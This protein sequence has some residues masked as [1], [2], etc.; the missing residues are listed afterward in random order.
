MRHDRS[1]APPAEGDAGGAP[2]AE[3][4]KRVAVRLDGVVYSY[5]SIKAV[6]GVTLEIWSGKVMCLVGPNGSGKTTLLKLVASLVRP[7]RGVVYVNGKDARLYRPGEIARA[8]SFSEPHL[9]RT[10]PMRAIDFVLTSRY[11]FQRT[12]Q[13]FESEEDLRVVESVAE[14]LGIAHLL[15]RRLDQLSSG[16]LQRVVIAAALAKR[17][18]VLLLDEPSAFLDVRNRFEVMEIVRRYARERNAAVVVA[19]HDLF[20][21]SLYCDS[22]ALMSGGRIAALGPPADV[23]SSEVA[24]RVYGV[25]IETVRVDG[26]TVIAVPLPPQPGGGEDGS[27]NGRERPDESPRVFNDAS[28]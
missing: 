15:E 21:A 1:T 6:D 18:R 23:F 25:G 4:E 26:T 17:P 10:L 7:L 8:F 16:E 12:L 9:P 13:Y 19:L 20:T 27:R 5:G 28:A 3:P 2:G 14:E 24:K 11:P 22:V